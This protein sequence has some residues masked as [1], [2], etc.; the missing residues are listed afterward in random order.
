M[1]DL[2]PDPNIVLIEVR[3]S[4]ADGRVWKAQ[5]KAP[6]PSDQC[7]TTDHPVARESIEPEGR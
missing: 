5:Q 1:S 7:E 2:V 3:G 4:G 6:I